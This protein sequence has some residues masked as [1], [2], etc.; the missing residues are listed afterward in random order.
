MSKL[1]DPLLMWLGVRAADRKVTTLLFGNMFLAGM[2]V[3]LF[4][5]CAYAL[6][7][8]RF[9]ASQLALVWI[10]MAVLGTALTVTINSVTSQF[11]PRNYLFTIHGVILAIMLLA[12]VLLGSFDED[13]LVFALPLCFELIYMLFSLQFIAQVT[14]LL[15][16]RQTK[17]LA[18][19]ARSGEFVAEIVAA[20]IAL[21][22]LQVVEVHDLIL[23]AAVATFGVACMVQLAAVSF[24]DALLP[25][26][27]DLARD[28]GRETRMF[29]LLRLPYVRL[30]A[31]CYGIYLLAY[32]FLD[33]A[34]YSYASE[35]YPDK[36]A[37]AEFLARFS[38]FSGTLTL[39]AMVFL[40]GPFLRRFGILGGVI[41][42]P[43]LISVGCVAVATLEFADAST[44][45]VFL[46][47]MA[48]YALRNVLQAAIWKPSVAILFQVLPDR[49]RS[50]GTALIEGVIDPLSGGV[51][52]IAMYLITR[53][54]ALES[55]YYLLILAGFLLLWAG[56]SFMLRKL[57]L[58]NL[59]VSLQ[60]RKLGELDVSQLD[61]ESLQIIKNGLE[62]DYPAQVFYCLNLLEEM[63]HPEITELI[64]QVLPNPSRDIRIDVLRRIA[65]M[66]IQ[67]LAGRVNERIETEQDPEVLGQVLR[68]YAALAP[69]SAFDR[70]EGFLEHP[71]PGVRLGAMSGILLAQPGN[72][73]VQSH[74][75]TLVRSENV[76]DRA[77]AAD[78]LAEVRDPAYSGY[79][80]ELLDD[81]EKS[82]VIRAM[83]ATGRVRDAR[84]A[85][86]LV[87]NLSDP[88]L[89]P[90]A[91]QALRR[92]EDDALYELDL[93]FTSPTSGRRE[94]IAIVDI[95]REIGGLHAMET[96]LRHIEITNPEI[97]HRIY[98]SL[99]SLHYQADPDDRYIFVNKLDAEVQTICWLLAAM[100]DLNNVAQY[101][102]VHEALAQELD[103]R[104]DKMLLL[105]SFLYPSIVMLDTR[106][107]L[108]SKVSELRVFALEV[109]DNVLTAEIKQIVLPVLEDL[110][111]SA[112]LKALSPRFPQASLSPVHRFDNIMAVHFDN[113]FYWTRT[114]LLHQIGADANQGHL[115]R[116]RSVLDDPEPIVRE[117]ALWALARLQP[118][119]LRRT[120]T[121]HADDK[122]A[123]VSQIVQFLLRTASD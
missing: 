65:R 49:Q 31:G 102:R 92:Y 100:D 66:G 24:N 45:A 64:K 22:L 80:V 10:L 81:T 52:G 110:P 113:A 119:A 115:E 18:G 116:V 20:S 50:Q 15:N 122:S 67:P 117:T 89:S 60:K 14:K 112:R 61:P 68:T 118:P 94:K 47:M 29:G 8:E 25:T 28:A 71:H 44:A 35:Q 19:L 57:Y 56:M 55:Q 40:F 34:F 90:A 87:A 17:R 13:W 121:A 23:V 99:A 11:R 105:I 30:I 2:A 109:L 46:L 95:I 41:A 48:T 62:S 111:V 51:A 12:W 5:F 82:I 79:L 70:L 83:V 104:R 77:L 37:Y 38:T 3:T 114:T 53:Q 78:I 27:L 91:Q 1:V 76:Q 26:T 120:L 98:M 21:V 88:A 74:L 7:M 36:V 97:R 42:F 32:F 9:G 43:M 101:E 84:L 108:D 39:I 73:V 59:V 54:L 6:F 75:L 96:L 58:S 63:D 69:N 93:G 86:R 103:V 85:N 33:A 106:A 123:N 107:N 4:R 72:D 16:V